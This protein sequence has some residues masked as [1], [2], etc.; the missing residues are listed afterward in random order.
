MTDRKMSKPA[1]LKDEVWR[2]H[3]IWMKVMNEQLEQNFSRHKARVAEDACRSDALSAV[4]ERLSQMPHR[5]QSLI[6]KIRV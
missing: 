2:Q 5:T 6:N 3:L 1:H 4:H